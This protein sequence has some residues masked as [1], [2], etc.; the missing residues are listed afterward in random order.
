[1]TI[2][3]GHARTGRIY[4]AGPMTG[5]ESFNF[6][7]FNAKADELRNYG[8]TVLNPADHGILEGAQWGDYLRFDIG[9]LGTCE[10]I[11]MLP[12]WTKSKG[13]RLEHSIA[14]ALDMTI[15][16][17]EGAEPAEF[18]DAARWRGF[19]KAC[20]SDDES[21]VDMLDEADP[22]TPEE[23]NAVMDRWLSQ[24]Q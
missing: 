13:A 21:F 11:C 9:L 20:T 12:G 14:V 1:M 4:V 18:D 10:A 19:V 2:Q 8:W 7:A 3:L 5:I 17:S 15:L 23:F 6:P 22:E 24:Q 16:F